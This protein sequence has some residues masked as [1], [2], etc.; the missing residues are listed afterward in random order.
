[1]PNFGNRCGG[2][3]PGGSII[4]G[5]IPG[6][7]IIGGGRGR[8]RVSGPNSSHSTYLDTL[9][10]QYDSA[11]DTSQLPSDI[12]QKIPVH[13]WADKLPGILKAL[14]TSGSGRKRRRTTKTTG[15]PKRTV[16]G[17]RMGFNPSQEEILNVLS[18]PISGT[19]NLL[20]KPGFLEGL[21]KLFRK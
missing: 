19:Y 10:R 18:H 7:S 8:G 15:K 4:G 20:K 11:L 13:E 6:G 3:I 14:G 5:A 16:K 2:A 17:G 1:M 12:L 9:L 21:K